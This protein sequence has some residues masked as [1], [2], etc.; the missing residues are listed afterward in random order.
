MRIIACS[1]H[2]EV[3]AKILTPLPACADGR[4]GT[5]ADPGAWPAGL[6]VHRRIVA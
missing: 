3:I 2:A 6:P 1:E 4:Q 5:L